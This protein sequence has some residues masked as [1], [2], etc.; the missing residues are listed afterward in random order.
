MGCQ[1]R[2]SGREGDNWP[3]SSSALDERASMG[4]YTSGAHYESCASMGADN[5]RKKVRYLQVSPD[6]LWQLKAKFDGKKG[7]LKK[8][9]KT[10]RERR[11]TKC[12]RLNQKMSRHLETLYRN[13]DAAREERK[14]A[15]EQF[16]KDFQF[17]LEKIAA[18]RTRCIAA[19]ENF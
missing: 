10:N 15:E 6:D 12:T 19:S 8:T 11:M 1:K 5:V 2:R 4:S 7:S 16:D 17:M 3:S 9:Y 14:E 18:S 13:F